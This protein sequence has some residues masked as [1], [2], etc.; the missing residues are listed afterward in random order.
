MA[1]ATSG[2]E[3]LDGRPGDNDQQPR[4][5]EQHTA[6]SLKRKL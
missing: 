6:M 3:M 4:D 5:I 2:W 1:T